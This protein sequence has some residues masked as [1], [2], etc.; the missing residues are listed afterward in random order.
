MKNYEKGLAL[1]KF[2]CP[3]PTI[4]KSGMHDL[5]IDDIVV[6]ANYGTGTVRSVLDPTHTNGG[7]VNV[8]FD[9][10]QVGIRTVTINSLSCDGQR[11]QFVKEYR[12]WTKT[13]WPKTEVETSA[14]RFD[15][16][17]CSKCGKM[18]S[19]NDPNDPGKRHTHSQ[20]NGIFRLET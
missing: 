4:T 10:A 5:A 2:Y 20:C 11:C 15:W 3:P 14:R 13:R 6:Q 1:T 18:G 7:S 8:R 19:C 16:G 12:R 9:D 17:K